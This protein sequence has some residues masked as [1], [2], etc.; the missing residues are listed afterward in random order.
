MTAGRTGLVL[1]PGIDGTGIFF[2]PLV[3]SLPE[4]IPVSVITYP[5]GVVL[6]LEEHARFVAERFPADGVVIVAE[7]F[8]GLVGLALLHLGPEAVKGAVFSAA[9][10]G[11]LH[12][13]LIHLLSCVPGMESLVTKLPVSLLEHFLFGPFSS[14]ELRALLVR[15]LSEID[16]K[17]LR[18]RA[19]LTASGY[20]NPDE[21]FL[22]PCL[23]LEAARDRVVPP[24]AASWF[25]GHFPHFVHER[26]DAPHCLLQ[27]KPVECSAKIMEF[28][29]TIGS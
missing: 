22:T 9:F 25:A 13:H 4:D 12:R 14:N 8:S 18:Q 2:E 20:P 5:P 17:G 15:G 26:F 27:T 7:S 21:S 11:P 28:I 10:A 23:Y 1:M 19:R 24:Q 29:E 6:S 16:G 3:N